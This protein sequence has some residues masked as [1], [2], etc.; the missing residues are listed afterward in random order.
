YPA[1]WF[2]IARPLRGVAVTVAAAL[3][4]PFLWPLWLHPAAF[5]IG[6]DGRYRHVSPLARR[7]L[8]YQTTPRHVPGGQA[9]TACGLWGKLRRR[10]V[11]LPGAGGGG[12]TGGSA[13]AAGQQGFR[14][15]G[16][17]EA[18]LLGGSP[19]PLRFLAVELDRRAPARLADGGRELRPSLL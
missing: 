7:L 8:P 9:S 19:A 15:M 2:M 6:D 11:W 12:G 1:L 18:D 17:G 4:A 10:D 5:P 14:M 16:S 3:A 13:R